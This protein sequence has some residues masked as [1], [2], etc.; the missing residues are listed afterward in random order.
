MAGFLLATQSVPSGTPAK[1]CHCYELPWCSNSTVAKPPSDATVL[2]EVQSENS[3]FKQHK[4]GSYKMVLE[5]V[6]RGHWETDT[7][8][9]EDGY[10]NA[11]KFSKKL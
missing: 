5:V 6:E 11:K 2:F 1:G 3:T 8:E 4:G 9:A 7:A 10:Y